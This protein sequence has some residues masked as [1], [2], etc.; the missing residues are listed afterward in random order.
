MRSY[1]I[2][3]YY[4]T[5]TAK[6]GKYRKITVKLTNKHGRQA[7]TSPRLL[8]LQGLGQDERPG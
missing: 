1:Y 3:G 2:L 7:R 4:S 5:N 8:G 6:D